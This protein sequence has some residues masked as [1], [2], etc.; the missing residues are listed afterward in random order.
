MV[1]MLVFTIIDG[2]GSEE[3]TEAYDELIPRGPE[4]WVEKDFTICLMDGSQMD[5]TLEIAEIAQVGLNFRL[6]FTYN[7][8]WFCDVEYDPASNTSLGIVQGLTDE[9]V[10]QEDK[11]KAAGQSRF[12]ED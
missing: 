10:D 2:P 12:D 9:E 8:H 4:T 7:N 11:R 6:D 5:A 1:D 3:M